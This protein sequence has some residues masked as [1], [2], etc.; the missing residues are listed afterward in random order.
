MVPSPSEV[1]LLARERE[2][3]HRW[4]SRSARRCVG[5][6][7]PVGIAAAFFA[8]IRAISQPHAA[9]L[10][11]TEELVQFLPKTRKQT[12]VVDNNVILRRA[13]RGESTLKIVLFWL[14]A[15]RSRRIGPG[16]G[17]AFPDPPLAPF[18]ASYSAGAKLQP[19]SARLSQPPTTT[20]PR[21]G[22]RSQTPTSSFRR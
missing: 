15:K 10:G 12:V 13:L 8:R 4:S 16:P 21:P 20:S 19:I 1:A 6:H 3:E 9:E 11:I 17:A 5:F 7:E 22:S 18:A 2:P 14:Q